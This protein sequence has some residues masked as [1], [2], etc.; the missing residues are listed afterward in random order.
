[1][2]DRETTMANTYCH[3]SMKRCTSPQGRWAILWL[4]VGCWAGAWLALAQ[5]RQLR[6]VRLWE[7]A[8]TSNDQGDSCERN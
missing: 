1:M 7:R 5:R 2:R 4:R 6:R 3:P 8:V